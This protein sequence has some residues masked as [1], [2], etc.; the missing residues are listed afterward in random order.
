MTDF[1]LNSKALVLREIN[2]R[3]GTFIAPADVD[4]LNLTVLTSGEYNT[5]IT[6]SAT[7]AGN[8]R[9]SVTQDYNRVQISEVFT[10]P[11]VFMTIGGITTTADIITRINSLYGTGF[12]NDDIIVENVN[13]TALNTS[14][15]VFSLKAISTSLMYLGTLDVYFTTAANIRDWVRYPYYEYETDGA[16]IVL[17]G[18]SKVVNGKVVV[19]KKGT[20]KPTSSHE[21][22][23][24]A[25]DGS[26]LLKES[27][28]NT[29]KPVLRFRSAQL[30][31]VVG[32]GGESSFNG[33]GDLLGTVPKLPEAFNDLMTFFSYTGTM[34][35][36]W[37]S[38]ATAFDLNDLFVKYGVTYYVD[39]VNG[40]DSALGTAAAPLKTFNAALDK[41]PKATTLILK[42]GT[43]Y[44]SARTLTDRTL[45]IY[46]D[47]TARATLNGLYAQ[48]TWT[49]YLDTDDCFQTLVNAAS[50]AGVV[51][52][53]VLASNGLPQRLKAVSAIN[54]VPTTPGSYYVSPTAIVVNLSN[55]RKPDS[56]VDIINKG[57]G[58]TVTGASTVMLNNIN[59][60]NTDLGVVS[61]ATT[62]ASIPTT[63]LK[64]C[65]VARTFAKGAVN[66]YG[67]KVFSQACTFYDGYSC[68]VYHGP[69]RQTIPLGLAAT[70][71][72]VGCI[73][74]G[75]Y[76]DGNGNC[77]GSIAG[78][79]TVGIRFEATYNKIDGV[80][81]EDYGTGTITANFE[82]I[83]TDGYNSDTSKGAYVCAGRT[84]DTS[85]AYGRSV[86]LLYSCGIPRTT[87]FAAFTK[88]NG[89]LYLYNTPVGQVAQTTLPTPY[90]FIYTSS[91]VN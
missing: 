47:S 67:S 10:Q 4:L 35:N 21:A 71:L 60:E 87:G 72:E 31:E 19:G 80:F 85:V 34:A 7:E 54:L 6:L 82:L 16:T 9:E 90:K 26:F 27:L 70:F 58:L 55:G 86:T 68:G 25:D 42:S 22:L 43:A 36:N 15:A 40:N 64:N 33:T 63:Y 5:R 61:E 81:V 20:F 1:S 38:F 75:I 13:P 56:F 74:T 65:I 37:M 76:Q 44:Y 12:T 88:A 78:P 62:V 24:L 23:T 18:S 53:S 11:I 29:D 45:G 59:V 50:I 32:P 2:A 69:D 91:I 28:A 14:I 52:R 49:A 84:A 66:N 48:G 77:R 79:G 17:S 30:L 46:T 3:Y 41:S 8:Y 73:I 83:C 57:T 39:A 51:D 89:E